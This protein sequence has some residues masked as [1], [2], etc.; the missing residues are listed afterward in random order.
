MTRK[1]KRVAVLAVMSG[2]LS[3]G[4]MFAQ[5]ASADPI[6]IG[7]GACKVLL[8]RVDRLLQVCI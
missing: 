2:L 7:R 6:V 5:P 4:P 3:V 1:V 8:L